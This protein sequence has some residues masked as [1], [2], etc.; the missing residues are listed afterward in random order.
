MT[1]GRNKLYAM[2]FIACLAGYFWLYLST[3]KSFIVNTS[4]EVCIIK[5]VS[6]LPCPSCGSTRSII[7]LLQGDFIKSLSINPIGIILSIIMIFSPGWITIDLIAKRDSLFRFYCKA[8]EYLKRPP[9][10]ILFAL[11]IVINWIWNIKKGV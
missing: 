3:S 2:L 11:L 8:Q 4:Y 5:K 7:S 10:S 1:L 6:N 9:Y